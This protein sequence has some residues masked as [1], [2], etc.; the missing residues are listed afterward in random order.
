[1]RKWMAAVAVCAMGMGAAAGADVATLEKQLVEARNAAPLTVEPFYLVSEPAKYFGNYEPRK[2]NVYRSGETMHFYAEPKNL[3]FPR[4][5]RGVYKPAFAVDLEVTAADGKSMKKANFATFE[6]ESRS[7]IQ[8]LYLNL[9]V[10]LTGA[11]PGKYNVKFVIRDSNSK[12]TLAFG[13]EIT[14]R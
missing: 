9:D 1:M 2:D 11:P 6:L 14:I 12:K 8:D 10:S 4:D 13:K 7:R 3:V 5:S